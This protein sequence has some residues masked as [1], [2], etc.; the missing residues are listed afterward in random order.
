MSDK[1]HCSLNRSGVWPGGGDWTQALESSSSTS[2]EPGIDSLA[3]V[4]APSGHTLTYAA[5]D[6]VIPLS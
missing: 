6:C 1:M 5:R 3:Q 4:I 2:G